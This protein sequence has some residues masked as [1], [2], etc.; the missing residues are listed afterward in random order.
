MQIK[1]IPCYGHAPWYTCCLISNVI[2]KAHNFHVE[3]YGNM[4][5]IMFDSLIDIVT[6]INMLHS[7]QKAVTF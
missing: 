3:P 2:D 6:I 7:F 5:A 1:T 4:F